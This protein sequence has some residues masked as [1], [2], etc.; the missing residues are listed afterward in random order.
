MIL[1]GPSVQCARRIFLPFRSPTFLSLSL[2]LSLPDLHLSLFTVLS[3]PL[4]F[5][6]PF[7]PSS[8]LTPI[9]SLPWPPFSYHISL[10]FLPDPFPYL[11]VLSV[12]LP[13]PLPS[14]SSLARPRRSMFF[15]L[16]RSLSPLPPL[17]FPQVPYFA[18]SFLHFLVPFPSISLICM[19]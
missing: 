15:V 3:A 16:T 9:T 12:P 17:S 7:S 10:L 1:S 5:L 18:Y 19:L 11:A 14:L 13:L 2:P 4:P 8:F 6:P